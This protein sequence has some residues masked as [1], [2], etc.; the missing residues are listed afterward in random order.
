MNA[1]LAN[2]SEHNIILVSNAVAATF[3]RIIA[4]ENIASIKEMC[5]IALNAGGRT[6]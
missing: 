4:Q 1:G 5:N 3:I 6:E 2:N